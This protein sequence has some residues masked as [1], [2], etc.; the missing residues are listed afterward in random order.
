M[1]V[2]DCFRRN[3]VQNS[4]A[5]MM[6]S[7]GGDPPLS[8]SA[9]LKLL[10]SSS[11]VHLRLL[12]CLYYAASLPLRA[13]FYQEYTISLEYTK[14][15]LADLVGTA[16]FSFEILTAYRSLFTRYQEADDDI[17]TVSKTSGAERSLTPMSRNPGP[18]GADDGFFVPKVGVISFSFLLDVL[19]TLP[20]EWVA[21][22]LGV[23]V[24]LVVYFMLNRAL[25]MLY[26]PK[27]VGDVMM[28]FEERDIMKNFGVQR[29]VLLFSG[30]ALAGHWCGCLFY[31]IGYYF[32]RRGEPRTWPEADGL[33]RIVGPSNA[34]TCLE[35][36]CGLYEIEYLEQLNARYI[37]SL[38]WAYITMITTG[39]GDIVPLTVPETIWCIVSM[40][41]GA[42]ITTCAIA[43]LQLLVTNLD[44][45]RTNFQLK[46]DSLKMFMVYRRLPSSLQN[47][48][49]SFYDYQWDLLR[50]ADEELF[51]SELPKSLQQQIANF[52]SRDLLKSLP[53]LRKA[54]NALLNALTDCIESNIYS[55]NDDILR[56]G[57][58]V[59]GVLLIARGECEVLKGDKVE[60]KMHRF[61]RFAEGSLFSQ[62]VSSNVVRSI[63]YCEI[64]LL[65]A[66]DFQRVIYNQ[67]DPEQI[68]KMEEISEKLAKSASK[69]NK[70]FGGGE[71][72]LSSLRGFK[73]RCIP[74]SP[75]R[76]W[77]S[78]LMFL[79][80]IY[81][82][83]S[84]PL[85]IM[86]AVQDQPFWYMGTQL[87]F[88]Y[89]VDLMFLIDLLFD[90]T[91][92]MYVEEGIVVTDHSRIRTNFF[93][94]HSMLREIIVCTPLDLLG[95]YIGARYN[96]ILRI[97][98]ILRI[99]KIWKYLAVVEKTIDDSTYNLDQAARRVFKFQFGL[100]AICHWVGCLWYMTADLSSEVGYP[101]HDYQNWREADEANT[102]FNVK[103]TDFGG[104]TA[105]YLRS[106]YWAIVG[107][108]TVGYGDIVP[109]N[110]LETTFAT[111]II[112][113]GGLLIPAIVGGLAA[114]MGNLNQSTKLHR[115]KIFKVR[116]YMRR[117][118]FD[119]ELVDKIL[120]YYDYLW[121]RQRGVDEVEIMNE[122]PGPLQ[123]RVAMCVNGEALQSIPF[124]AG[125][126]EGMQQ[127]LVSMLKPRVFL[128]N[129]L[130]ITAGEV[131]KE[132]YMIERGTCIVSNEDKTVSY[133]V[134]KEGDY[135]GESCLLGAT[136]RM[137]SVCAVTYCD[138]FVLGKD[139]FNEV[140]GA[141]VPKERREITTLVQDAIHG[142]QIRNIAVDKNFADHPKCEILMDGT[143]IDV[144]RKKG[145]VVDE[146]A[147]KQAGGSG[148]TKKKSRVAR[149]NPDHRLRHFWN[150]LI[151]IICVYN[152]FSIPF[153]LSFGG[154]LSSY[155]FDWTLDILFFVDVYLNMYEF[156]FVE[157]GE[158]VVD[159]DKVRNHYYNGYFKLDFVTMFPLDLFAL[160]FY[161]N[162]EMMLLMLAYTRL[163]KLIRLSR[164]FG[165]LADITRALEDTNIPLQPIEMFK[166]LSGVILVA[167]WAACGFYTLAAD[168]A[169]E[170]DCLDLGQRD[171]ETLLTFGNAYGE[172]RW[173]ETWIQKQ[174][175]DD[176]VGLDGGS[177]EQQYLRSFNWA[178][179]TLVVV[180]IG[181][182]VPV[183]SYETLY[184]FLLMI[185]GV[186]VNATIIG[187][188][189]NIVANL[190]SDST[191]FVR[192]A[193]DIKHF[194]HMH[195]VDQDLQDR[196]DHFM[197]YLWTAHSGMMNEGGFIQELPH[198][199]QMAISDHQKLSY[200]KDCPFFDFCSTE[201]IKALAMCLST[202][203]FSMGDVLIQYNDMGQE[204]FF[205][206]RGSVEVVSGDGST[207]FATLTKGSFFGET[208][209]FFKQKRGATIRAKEFCEVY[210]LEK[211]DL[212]NELR[213][214]EFD[215]SRM[216]DVFTKIANSNKRRNNAVAVNLKLSAK[217]GTKLNKMIDA[218][219]GNMLQK[220]KIRRIYQ[221]NSLF[222]AIW[223]IIATVFTMWYAISIF[224]RVGFV[225]HD[226][227]TLESAIFYLYPESVIDGFFLVDIYF[228]YFCFPVIKDGTTIS[229]SD[230]IKKLYA[231]NWM[232]PDMISCLPLDLLILVPSIERKNIFFLR[233]IHF[234]RI[235]RLPGYFN[236]VNHYLSLWNIRIP[237]SSSLLA[238]M[239]VYYILLNHL[240]A[241]G[242]F[243]IHRYVERDVHNTWATMD[244][245]Q[246][247]DDVEWPDM[248]L[249][250]WDEE[251]GQH[252]ICSSVNGYRMSSCY[253]RSFFFVITTISTVG[254]G[255]IAP[256]TEIETVY[257]NIVVLS[258]ACIF[259]GIIGSFSAFLSHNDTSGPNAFKLKMQKL[260][261]YMKYRKLPHNLQ[262]AILLHH[263]HRW[264]KSQILDEKA[265]MTILPRPLQLELSYAVVYKVIKKVAILD[266]CSLI[267]R[268]RIAHNLEVQTCPPQSII[269]EAG[270]IGWDIYFIGSGLVRVVLPKDLSVLDEAGRAASKR[271][272]RKADAIGNLYRIGNH[273]GESCLAS[274]SGVRQET[275]EARS[276]AELYLL[277]KA[278]LDNICSYMTPDGKDKFV[279]GLMTRNG[280][281]RH[282]FEDD[283]EEDMEEMNNVLA[284]REQMQESLGNLGSM[285]GMA[286]GNVRLSGRGKRGSGIFGLSN[287]N[288]TLSG[289][290]KSG[291]PAQNSSSGSFTSAGVDRK[292]SSGYIKKGS[293]IRRQTLSIVVNQPAPREMV[294]LRSFSAEASEEAMSQKDRE[295]NKGK[296][297]V[298]KNGSILEVGGATDAM[299]AV[300]Q[301]RMLAEA[302]NLHIKG[303][304]GG[305][306]DESDSD[307]D[308][309]D[310]SKSMSASMDASGGSRKSTNSANRG[311][312]KD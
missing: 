278:N 306:S 120:R 203:M 29:S 144:F 126:D 55:P 89:A 58:Q 80:C 187:N 100:I 5:G 127:Y 102:T 150:F 146:D 106:V 135:F 159:R 97:S 88:G 96:N 39:F 71:D 95:F 90:S 112:L 205:L 93:Q 173:G 267:M 285:G 10:I 24:G 255:D 40:Y 237:A 140:M 149:F 33:Y 273:F 2:F 52:M 12:A 257:E 79:G 38:Y 25:R 113:F 231:S 295:E 214:R 99:T 222:R 85:S 272:K 114:Y 46:M 130:L 262:T 134:L 218:K 185:I 158:L 243:I 104:I 66:D 44:A 115:G 6:P 21:W 47:R 309:D 160:V 271:A 174:M 132:M 225:L 131:G 209:L 18:Q 196:V 161:G 168:R 240:A 213:Q 84:I 298:N 280:N 276:M 136:V 19:A 76:K 236:S 186:T 91:F 201:I 212:D 207:V 181:D 143:S 70:L 166:L 244:C 103:H 105:G 290:S 250:R 59:K 65:P 216:L 74:N 125:C 61:D 190:Q 270:D 312:N 217:E 41:I 286:G 227:E 94:N 282:T 111:V 208:A 200:I 32:A 78:C 263:K 162:D 42:L 50:G 184:A 252:D 123:Q 43:N 16:F 277:S 26:L 249:A 204:M 175:E 82:I 3:K 122:L 92:F 165:A 288:A 8:F 215:L 101:D 63:T 230:K 239:F 142:K 118:Q 274:M 87:I 188:V 281:V 242:W 13:A 176:K 172:C 202:L 191:D 247:G 147:E 179:P 279:N 30:M 31:M 211:R 233:I 23:R 229:D 164:I 157:Q 307:S 14:F 151:L 27:Y 138:C 248:C 206:E 275:S 107:M 116:N 241:C 124:F 305:S 195:K 283:E 129:D 9:N 67:C 119:Q 62:T 15:I 81:L 246:A 37:R 117:A 36:D 45:A 310:N 297:F 284:A 83:F 198:T 98:K 256:Q 11:R 171:N 53:V 287:G 301:I 224:L 7:G 154:K 56:P 180:V 194:M 308:S 20:L 34:T 299:S 54:N 73:K 77:W 197:T 178:L 292:G 49:T 193:D 86:I 258:G 304:G 266:E 183:T 296:S 219:D 163:P 22:L 253:F 17:S 153:R 210:Q 152:A 269:Y 259:A 300:E 72:D 28:W 48:I 141:Y 182:V 192:R 226:E 155:W 311:N 75:F 264:R 232:I 145:K 51:L 139:A 260:Q 64:F 177:V 148:I 170:K 289:G 189:A 291:V 110:D 235:F 293:L 245:P 137:A 156:S 223:V 265:V 108:S 109:T 254:Y 199:L 57:E 169:D 238:R 221:P 69:A 294:R 268:K 128:P 121:S 1:G 133:T 4:P 35:M 251:T 234:L 220:R 303:E 60:R 228:Q 261:E 167:H 302:G 68:K